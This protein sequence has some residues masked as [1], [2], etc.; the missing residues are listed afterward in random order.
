M[1]SMSNPVPVFDIFG[2]CRGDERGEYDLNR[3]GIPLWRLDDVVRYFTSRGFD[4]I[5]IERVS[6]TEFVKRW[7]KYNPQEEDVL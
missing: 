2:Y 6:E 4:G 1:E 3:R 7:D 5:L